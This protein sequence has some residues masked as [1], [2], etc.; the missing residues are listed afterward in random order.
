MTFSTPVGSAQ[1]VYR[2]NEEILDGALQPYLVK[3][4]LENDGDFEVVKWILNRAQPVPAIEAF[5]VLENEIGDEGF[6]VGLMGRVPFQE[7]MLDYMGEER[8]VYQM[9]DNPKGFGYL[10]DLLTAQAQEILGI[11]LDSSALMVEFADNFDGMITSPR[12]F[13]RHCIPFMQ[14]AADR[15]HAE[16][17]LLGSHMDGNLK[18][19][20]NLI[21]ECGVD[22]VESFSPAPLSQ[23]TFREAWEAWRGKVLM[24]GAIPSPLFE[25][26][27]PEGELRGYVS[28]MLDLIGDDGR[29][30]L[31]IADQAVGPTLIER[32]KLVS[33]M[34]GRL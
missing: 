19:L 21:P 15:V 9:M 28:E 24:W 4:I 5:Q 20:L 14:E 29:I 7:V 12:L 3:H 6:S 10:L 32:V 2:S 1:L 18:P 16:G 25:P 22:V 17:R 27:V 31:G 11:A 23:L 34:L 8:A 30:I 33:E 26:H 13:E